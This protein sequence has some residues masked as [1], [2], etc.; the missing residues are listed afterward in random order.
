MKKS[1]NKE[2]TFWRHN[3]KEVSQKLAVPYLAD[4]T[5][6]ALIKDLKSDIQNELAKVKK[7]I[8]AYEQLK[9]EKTKKFKDSCW[10]HIFQNLFN[11]GLLGLILVAPIMAF[12][13]LT[14]LMDASLITGLAIFGAIVGAISSFIVDLKQYPFLKEIAKTKIH[15]EN[16]YSLITKRVSLE[17]FKDELDIVEMKLKHNQEKQEQNE[18]SAEEEVYNYGLYQ[19]DYFAAEQANLKHSLDLKSYSTLLLQ[20]KH[21]QELLTAYEETQTAAEKAILVSQIDELTT[22]LMNS[23]EMPEVTFKRTR[24]KGDN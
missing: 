14:G 6:M 17:T 2:I 3:F 20:I 12:G 11:Y 13:H 24:V 18:N 10:G 5:K 15:N 16:E 8:H 9:N 22:A 4:T 19:T 21:L 23:Y 7:A 1:S